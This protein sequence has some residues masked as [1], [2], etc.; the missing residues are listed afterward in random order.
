ML[1][2]SC[3]MCACFA[4]AQESTSQPATSQPSDQSGGPV[5]DVA[6]KSAIDANMDKDVTIEGVVDTA[7]WSGNGKVMR[8]E[9]KGNQQTKF[10]AVAFEKKKKDF[11]AA[12]AGDFAKAL[13]GARVRIR[14][15]LK[16]YRDR[17]AVT[18]DAPSQVTILE[19][20]P[21]T[22]ATNPSGT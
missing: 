12:F 5:V 17:P 1:T 16:M 20:G 15:K 9:F 7:A 8:V 18:M 11:D 21:S 19:P 2:T 4:Q 13:V 14:G 10:Q 22:P 6:D 3:L